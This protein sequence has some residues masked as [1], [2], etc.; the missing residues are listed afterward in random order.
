MLFNY[1]ILGK[2]F[3]LGGTGCITFSQTSKEYCCTIC[4]YCCMQR[5]S[6]CTAIYVFRCVH[7]NYT[8]VSRE[9]NCV[10]FNVFASSLLAWITLP[11]QGNLDTCTCPTLNSEVCR[12]GVLSTLCYHLCAAKCLLPHRCIVW[13]EAYF[14][15]RDGNEIFILSIS[16]SRREFPSLNLVLRDENENFFF[17]ISGFE[18]RTRIEIFFVIFYFRILAG[19]GK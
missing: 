10:Q 9:A 6:D 7:W 12:E 16:C 1:I 8:E 14:N 5:R 18:T 13:R 19:K 3:F 17:S 2:M 15:S 11:L 4:L